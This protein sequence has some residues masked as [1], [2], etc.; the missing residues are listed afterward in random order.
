MAFE[1]K[2]LEDSSV[3]LI[4]GDRGKNYPKHKDFCEQGYCLF[5]SAK[6]VTKNGLEFN[7][8]SFISESK[9]SQ[10]RSG[11]LQRGDIVVTTRGTIGNIAYYGESVPF[12]HVRINSGM[13]I[14]RPDSALW[15]SR[16]LY[17]VLTS[18]FISDQIRALVSGSAVPQ[19][20]A[21][22][23][24][25][26]KLP[27]VPRY[28]QDKIVEQLG[29]FLDKHS[30]NRHMNQ[31]LE[32]MAQTLFKSW[33]VDF[34]PVIDN[35]LDAGTPIPDELQARAELRKITRK[36]Q[37]AQGKK[38]L[39]EDIRQ[40]FPCDF[41]LS[42]EPSVGISGWVPKGWDV[43][44]VS[45]AIKVNPRVSLPKGKVVKFADMKA[46]PTTGYIVGEVINKAYSGGA[47]FQM[48]D[49]LLARITP[50]LQNGKTALVDFLS[51]NEVGFGSTEFIVLRASENIPYSFVACLAREKSFRAHCM[52]SMVG[53]SG[54]QRVQNACFDAF[55]LALPKQSELMKSFA[56]LTEPSFKKISLNGKENQSL[57]RLRDTLLPKLISGELRLD[58]AEVNELKQ[59]V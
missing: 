3:Q 22:D 2:L 59:A 39:P 37:A 13:M 47:K 4:D 11:K 43:T 23:L 51:E 53:S 30:L 36:A 49:V 19:L 16:F 29:A 38:G 58:S 48:N 45:K 54:R 25:K 5:L 7:E 35:A 40:L 41:E 27:D 18:K 44:P 6:N 55:Y 14:F 50:C 15:N 42:Q 21:R 56:E 1:V 12:E 8:L 52:Q 31:T 10:L 20:P 32:Q 33:F 34:D 17:F 28:E 24:K 46:I 57:S 26:F 9:D